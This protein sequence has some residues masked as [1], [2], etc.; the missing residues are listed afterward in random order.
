MA[1]A[2]PAPAQ[3][4]LPESRGRQTGRAHS[5]RGSGL[6]SLPPLWHDAPAPEGALPGPCQARGAGIPERCGVA[7][8]WC[9]GPVTE[10]QGV[11]RPGALELCWNLVSGQSPGGPKEDGACLGLRD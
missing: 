9:L 7:E 2:A 11:P 6:R 10:D 8:R 5:A 4:T 3:P 1:P